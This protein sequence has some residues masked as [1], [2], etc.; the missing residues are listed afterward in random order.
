[1][2]M[3]WVAAIAVGL[4]MVSAGAPLAEPQVMRGVQSKV[5]MVPLQR[6]PSYGDGNGPIIFLMITN[7]G[8][9]AAHVTLR[10]Y[11]DGKM[12]EPK[13]TRSGT[14]GVAGDQWAN[15]ERAG[16]LVP[17]RGTITSR[18]LT[19]AYGLEAVLSDEPVIVAAWYLRD[20][21]GIKPAQQ[22][23]G[24]FVSI[25]AFPVDCGGRDSEAY[26]CG[27]PLTAQQPPPPAQSI[28]RQ[29]QR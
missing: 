5:W 24:R 2:L 17:A 4:A 16:L 6:T 19:N 27:Q 28:A 21:P 8:P 7:A 26:V 12:A 9:R 25:E 20:A 22:S 18:D 11:H 23:I 15:I 14:I 10:F 3:R 13:R 1:M 29:A